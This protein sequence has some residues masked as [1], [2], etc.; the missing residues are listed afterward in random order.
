MRK[1]TQSEI[2]LAEVLENTS[3]AENTLGIQMP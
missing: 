2:S 1:K 3:L